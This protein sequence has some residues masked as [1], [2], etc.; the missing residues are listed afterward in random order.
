MLLPSVHACW[1]PQL[2]ESAERVETVC[3]RCQRLWQ[4]LLC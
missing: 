4:L 3:G 1:L 2:F